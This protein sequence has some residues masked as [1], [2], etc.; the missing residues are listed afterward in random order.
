MLFFF[1][2]HS[3]IAF[4]V[5][6]FKKPVIV[7]FRLS[8]HIEIFIILINLIFQNN[9]FNKIFGIFPTFFGGVATFAV[10]VWSWKLFQI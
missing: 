10:E 2:M 1:I 8:S 5:S 3:K 4:Y 7:C 6:I 9:F